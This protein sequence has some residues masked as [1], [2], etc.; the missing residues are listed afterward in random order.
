MT[1]EERAE[2]PPLDQSELDEERQKVAIAGGIIAAV[3]KNTALEVEGVAGLAATLPERVKHILGAG[4][5]GVAVEFVDAR[6]VRI[7]LH[8]E[9]GE[10]RPLPDVARE[11]KDKVAE[12]VAGVSGLG[13]SDV[14]VHID[15]V[16]GDGA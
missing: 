4:F 16:G 1:D 12:K 6:T 8:L 9:V 2:A 13:V 10:G 15:K 3:A 11:V 7:D 5:A 14:V